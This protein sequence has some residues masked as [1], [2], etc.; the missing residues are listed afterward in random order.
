MFSSVTT[1][2]FIISVH[3]ILPCLNAVRFIHCNPNQLFL[4]YRCV[5]HITVSR[6]VDEIFKD[7][8]ILHPNVHLKLSVVQLGLSV[9]LQQILI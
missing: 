7:L 8:Y 1:F 6:I 9:I 2:I 4:I 3:F 5:E